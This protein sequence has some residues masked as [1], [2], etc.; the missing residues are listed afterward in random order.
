[1]TT[2]LFLHVEYWPMIS[3]MGLTQL[4]TTDSNIYCIDLFV[5]CFALTIESISLKHI[6]HVGDWCHLFKGVQIYYTFSCKH[7]YL[8]I[9][10]RDGIAELVIVFFLVTV[11]CFVFKNDVTFSDRITDEMFFCFSSSICAHVR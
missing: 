2:K 10:R 6:L 8:P 5:H 7:T 9:Y 1:M 4:D 11:R 3:L